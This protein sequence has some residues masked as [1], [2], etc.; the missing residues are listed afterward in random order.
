MIYFISSSL[1]NSKLCL[2]GSN[3]KNSRRK[4]MIKINGQTA[5]AANHFLIKMFLPE[6][7]SLFPPPSDFLQRLASLMGQTHST[8]NVWTTEGVQFHPRA[9]HK[10]ATYVQR[11]PGRYEP[12]GLGC[13]KSIM[14]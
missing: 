7:L 6:F 10:M 12:K 13:T 4:K 5:C 14:T 8:R 2:K 3:G 1:L 11:R 9:V